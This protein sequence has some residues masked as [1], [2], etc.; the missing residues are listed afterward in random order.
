MGGVGH[1]WYDPYHNAGA[2]I[3]NGDGGGDKR[4]GGVKDLL[5]IPGLGKKKKRTDAEKYAPGYGSGSGSGAGAGASAGA[6]AGAQPVGERER[7]METGW[8]SDN[9]YAYGH[10]SRARSPYDSARAPGD[11]S[12]PGQGQDQDQGQDQGQGHSLG[13]G[14]VS[15]YSGGE[16][17]LS[18][19]TAKKGKMGRWIAKAKQA[20]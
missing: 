20:V 9:E 18:E 4:A 14:P 8:D 19:P 16:D 5:R 15:G 17:E 13:Q 10:D 11:S 7:E 6:V 3:D 12:P 1:E 2:G